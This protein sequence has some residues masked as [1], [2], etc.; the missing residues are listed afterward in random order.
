MIRLTVISGPDAGKKATF[1]AKKVLLGRGPNNDFSLRDGLVSQNHADIRWEGGACLF[2]DLKSRHGSLIRLQGNTLNL[3]DRDTAKEMAL[4]EQCHIILGETLISVE[5]RETTRPQSSLITVPPT[6][7]GEITG[8]NE[9]VVKRGTE[10]LD[11]VTRRLVTRD[12]RL[13]S[14]FKLAR[15]LNAVTDLDEILPLIAETTF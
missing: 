2:R 9:R 1:T 12:P 7:L 5:A 8:V 13:V 14:I 11:A 4:P 10:S 3:H 15:S 6:E